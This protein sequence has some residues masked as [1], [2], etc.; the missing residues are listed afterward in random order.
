MESIG[1]TVAIALLVAALAAWSA[2]AGRPPA[3]P[4]AGLGRGAAP[5][6]SAQRVEQSWSRD[7][8][9]PW[10]DA[11]ARRR[12]EPPIG[13][14]LGR[15]ARG[16]GEAGRIGVLG[17]WNFRRHV[18]RRVA[19]RLEDLVRNPRQLFVPMDPTLLTPGGLARDVAG[20]VGDPVEYVRSL[21]GLSAEEVVMRVTGDGGDLAGDVIVDVGQA[22]LQRRAAGALR[23]RPPDAPPPDA[24]GP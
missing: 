16:A 22:L 7:D 12:G 2:T 14:F 6:V 15:V 4:P 24:R 17:A 19:M 20:R 13:R 8:L 1:V 11:V 10:L 3:A 9:P 5:G 23:R 21:R 18:E